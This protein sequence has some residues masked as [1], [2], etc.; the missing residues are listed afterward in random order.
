MWKMGVVGVVVS[1]LLLG[2]AAQGQRDVT[3]P[4]D[5]VVGVPND[6]DWPTKETPP[7]AIDD[8]PS[9]KYLHFKGDFDP[10]VGPTGFR[11]T[12][13]VGASVVVGLTFTTANDHPARDP[14][15]FRL[16]GSNAGIDGP[17]TVIAAGEIVDF[18]GATDW[19]RFATT[20]TPIR[21][22][23]TV[24]YAHYEIVFTALRDAP[25]DNSMQIAEVEFLATI[26]KATSPDPVD[27]AVSVTTPLFQ[28]SRGDTAVFHDVYV[29]TSPELTAAD[30]KAARQPFPMYY[31]T[32]GLEA[33]VS[34]YWRVDEI[35]GDGT[36]AIGDV[37][38][39]TVTPET[40]WLPRPAD[41]ARYVA[42]DVTFEWTPGLY[43]TGHTVYVG[44]DRAAVEAGAAEV[45]RADKQL[46]TSYAPAGLEAGQT[47]YWRV[48]EEAGGVTVPG[49]VWSFTARPV[50]PTVDPS[51]VGWWKLEDEDPA[52]AVDYS[53]CDNYGTLAG[54]PQWVEGYFGHA[55]SFDGVDDGVDCGDDASLTSVDSV[56]VMGWIK[57]GA[58]G[59]DRK[60]ASD[61]DNSTG[62]Y[63]LGVFTN[64]MVE[65]EIRNAANQAV[66]NRN[67]TGG[68]VLDA[69]V[70]YHVAGVYNQGQ[71]IQTYVNGILDRE[72]VTSEAVGMSTGPLRLGRESWSASHWWLGLMDD[73]RV[74]NR[75]LTGEEIQEAM[76]G[77]LMLAWSP[78]PKQGANVDIRHAVSLSWSAGETAARHD[79]YLGTDND[80]VDAADMS[81]PEYQGRQAGTTLSLEGLVE[82]GGGAYFWRVDEVASDGTTVHKGLVWRFT[83]PDY[84]IV[85][86]LESYTD[87]EGSRIYETW[88]DGWT[89]HTG[90]VVGNLVAPFAEHTIVHSGRQ[91]MPLDYDN[92]TA[93]FYSEAEREF[94]PAQ[95]WTINSVDTLALSFRGAAANGAGKLYVA[96]EDSTGQVAVVTNDS[97]LTTT[98]WSE[99]TIPLSRLT[100]VRVSRV[101][102]L[103][104]GVGDRHAPAVGGS[105]RVYIDDIRLLTP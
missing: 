50:M 93:P 99:W 75:A 20:T 41:G 35:A 57:R 100:G 17:Y 105:G 5:P 29:G 4:G 10:N 60:I 33:G 55:L 97:A 24:A 27:G 68:T 61:Q 87:D 38:S 2:G 78:Q 67:A 22:S 76:R 12:P 54:G 30:L 18:S 51:L 103:Y 71:F 34:Y 43:A 37:W 14:V 72:L 25:S 84:L 52:S 66:L 28:W 101:K 11:V 6:N 62:G 15:A 83:V 65:F 96:V 1:V 63:K 56:S 16:S 91:S 90:S 39:F 70:W 45:K 79:V 3:K 88:T 44:S 36:V 26:E 73:V 102:K 9:T 13:S 58:L 19:P 8:D 94:L 82:F 42:T 80:A 49:M 59:G 40:A 95:D 77:D 89:N 46:Q 53:G 69:G 31:H 86:D 7:L 48:D 74:Y 98:A 47:Y 32:P 92:T 81:S 85:D 23:N 21:F 104:V 64:D